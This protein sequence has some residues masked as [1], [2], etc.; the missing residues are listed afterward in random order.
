[1]IALIDIDEA[2]RDAARERAREE[3]GRIADLFG[4]D[5]LGDGRVHCVELDHLSDEADGA[6]GARGIR[7]GAY[8]VDPHAPAP[9]RLEGERAHIAL[10]RR[11]C[12]AHPA[13]IAGD[14]A[15]G[16]EIAQRQKRTA[17]AEQ[18]SEALHE[19]DE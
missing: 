4:L 6:G 9:P 5:S 3:G 8:R 11:L 19:R 10:E 2:A 15:L 17:L 18:R 12:R 7:P 1:M 13:T 16:R 14:G